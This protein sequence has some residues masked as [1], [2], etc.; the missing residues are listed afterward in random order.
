MTS[1]LSYC[2]LKQIK[3]EKFS[4]FPYFY[5]KK[6]PKR[7]VNRHYQTKCAKYLNF[8]I[9]KTTNAI[10][11]KLCTVIK[12]I[13]FSLWVVPKFAIQIQNGGWLPY[14]KKWINGYISA[15]VLLIWTKFCK[16]ENPRLQTAPIFLQTF[17]SLQ[18]FLPSFANFWIIYFILFYMWERHKREQQCHLRFT[19]VAGIFVGSIP[20]MLYTLSWSLSLSVQVHACAN[21]SQIV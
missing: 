1:V 3:M 14:W 16:F 2:I 6:Q 21:N 20:V 10:A 13:K 11:D 5:P 12:T 7:G 15:M 18:Q 19:C 4:I 17:A 8:C 9:I